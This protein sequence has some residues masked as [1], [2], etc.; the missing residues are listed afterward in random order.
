[1]RSKSASEYGVALVIVLG[2][3]VIISALAV[4]FFSSVT[5]E[6]KASRNFASGVTTRQLAESTVQLVMGQI[7]NAT[8]RQNGAWASQPGMIKVFDD[9]GR[10][11]AF[12]KLY[13]SNE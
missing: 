6:L 13:S 12:V 2:F 4:A 1:M 7:R 5:T 11:D 9:D 10:A 8:N 3:L